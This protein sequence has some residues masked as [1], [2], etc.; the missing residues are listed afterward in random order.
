VALVGRP[1]VGKSRLF[2]CLSRSRQSIVHGRPGIIRDVVETELESGVTLLDT[3]GWGLSGEWETP[4]ELVKA[5]ERQVDLA[6]AD[7]VLFVLDGRE[8]P[9]PLDR[10]IAQKLRRTGKRVLPV[11]NKLDS[12]AMDGRILDFFP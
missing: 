2:N 12:E 7:A 9:L 11:V 8:G 5:V 10:E 4:E 3:G 1:N 6:M